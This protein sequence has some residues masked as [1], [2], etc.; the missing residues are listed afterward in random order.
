MT[1]TE[2]LQKAKEITARRLDTIKE[3]IPLR[4]PVHYHINGLKIK[5]IIDSLSVD[6]EHL[7][8]E[9]CMTPLDSSYE[10]VI[11]EL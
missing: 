7:S 3:F 5:C 1:D 4:K 11:I 9:I 10:R 6:T 8:L 2:I